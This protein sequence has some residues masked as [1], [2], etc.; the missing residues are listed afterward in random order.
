QTRSKDYNKN[1][2]PKEKTTDDT[3][4]KH[5]SNHPDKTKAQ[6][7]SSNPIPDDVP[8]GLKNAPINPSK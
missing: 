5:K 2:N 8:S 7:K 6:D 4:A 3:K 1:Y